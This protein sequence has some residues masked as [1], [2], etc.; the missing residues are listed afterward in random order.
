MESV[1]FFMFTDWTKLI[2]AIE[3]WRAQGVDHVFVYYHSS[4][5]HV[6]DVLIHYQNEGFITI[7]PWSLLP[8]ST[9]IDPNLSLYR[10]AHSLAHNDCVLR[11]N[12]EFGAVLD[13]DEVIV[14]RNEPLL[15]LVKKLFSKA[16][17]GA[18]SFVHRSLIL[19]PPLAGENFTF[20][21]MDFSGIQNA[22]EFH[23][24]GPPK[25]NSSSIITSL[26]NAAC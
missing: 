20:E 7:V 9:F 18:L 13:I 8:R 12:S 6:Y 5:N 24:R 10:L 21:T 23:L 4:S 1:F 17:V 3:V 14:S 15:S 16:S 25:V 19:S 26:A 11:L 2:F 22:T